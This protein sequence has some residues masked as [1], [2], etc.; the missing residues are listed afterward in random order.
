MAKR[1]KTVPESASWTDPLA[2][3]ATEAVRSIEEGMESVGKGIWEFFH[4]HPRVGGTLTG[5]VGLG[6]A[7]AVGVAELAVTVVAGYLGFR[8]FAYGESFSEALEKS[9]ELRKGELPDEEL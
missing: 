3:G 5:G 1:T 2:T 9:I 8:M 4:D 7:M 6:A